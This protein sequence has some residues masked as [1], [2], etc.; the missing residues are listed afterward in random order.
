ML[1]SARRDGGTA[2]IG[3]I[4][5]GAA[6]GLMLAVDLLALLILVTEG[7]HVHYS[8][9]AFV[10]TMFIALLCL[11]IVGGWRAWVR[12]RHAQHA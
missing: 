10:Y 6:V 5:W 2:V 8:E 4:L 9:E 11:P 1:D 3:R 7:F 12:G